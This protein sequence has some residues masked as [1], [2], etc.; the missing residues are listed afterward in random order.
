MENI[1]QTSLKKLMADGY[2]LIRF[3]DS[4]GKTMDKKIIK[5]S[6]KYGAWSNLKEEY[7][8]K[9]ARMEA[10]RKMIETGKYIYLDDYNL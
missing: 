3:S 9:K 10:A 1:R 7:P 2:V 6:R 5:E 4:G 8:S